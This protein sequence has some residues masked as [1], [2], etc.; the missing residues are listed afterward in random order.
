MIFG[1]PTQHLKS[2]L[3]LRTA[4]TLRRALRR[5]ADE[6]A[7]SVSTRGTAARTTTRVSD[8]RST[9]NRLRATALAPYRLF[10]GSVLF[11]RAH[12]SV[13][14]RVAYLFERET[15]KQTGASARSNP[16]PSYADQP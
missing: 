10:F 5:L 16:Q 1:T 14:D 8:S 7:A 15:E 12:G 11:E 3:E 2:Q 4:L 13:D 9:T 6:R